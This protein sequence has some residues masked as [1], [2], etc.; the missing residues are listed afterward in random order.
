MTDPTPAGEPGTPTVD[1]LGPSPARRSGRRGPWL[2][3]GALVTALAAGGVAWG[4]TWY[5]SDGAQAAEAVPANAIAYAGLTLDPSGEQKLDA[6]RAF[7]RFPELR[8]QLDLGKDLGDVD[9]N[10]SLAK[11]VLGDLDCPQV[12]LDDVDGWLGERAGLAALPGESEDD[13]VPLLTL[14]VTSDGDAARGLKDLIAC[15]GDDE[16]GAA[17]SDGWAAISDTEAHARKALADA[18]SSS[19]AEDDDYQRWTS[20][21]GDRGVLTAYVAPRAATYLESAVTDLLGGATGVTLGDTELAP[22]RRAV[23]AFQGAGLQAG[24]DGDALTLETAGGFGKETGERPQDGARASDLLDRLPDDTAV[25]LAVGAQPPLSDEDRAALDSAYREGLANGIAGSG[26]S[27]EVQDEARRLVADAPSYLD[28]LDLLRGG[29]ALAVG[30]SFFETQ[31]DSLPIALVVPG[32]GS[33][34]K[35]LLDQVGSMFGVPLDEL[36][37]Q[38]TRDGRTVVGAD[39]SFNDAILDGGGLG[40]TAGFKKVVPGGDLYGG[41]YGDLGPILTSFDQQDTLGALD[42]V[43]FGTTTD[44]D[45]TVHLRLRLTTK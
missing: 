43:G 22:L 26:T 5:K 18:S 42:R 7:K 36:V 4:V 45:G 31:G 19:L 33:G 10:R 15:S 16:L 39:K 35:A 27:E 2:I 34:A 9:L 12:S 3:G 1:I 25:A 14:E 44:D 37:S 40:S 23:K 29:F 30:R 6:L 28:V 8:D 24:F 11:L 38:E 20:A 41:L 21:A 13:V 32:D 17:V